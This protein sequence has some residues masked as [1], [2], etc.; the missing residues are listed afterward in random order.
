MRPEPASLDAIAS[1]LA[2]RAPLLSEPGTYDQEAAVAVCLRPGE[3]S[4]EALFVRRAEHPD[5]PWS[6][7]AA[8]PGGRR[9]PGDASLWE[10]AI[11]ETLEETGLDLRAAGTLLG[12]LDDVHPRVVVLPN[13]NIT[14]FVVSVPAEA[15]A[16]ARSEIVAVAWIPLADLAMPERAGLRI[17]ERPSGRR[18]F[19][20]IHIADLE[21]WGLTHR[22]L[23]QLLEIAGPP[24]I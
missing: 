18:E 5:D 4:I 24:S 6:G 23:T 9:D 21:I 13:L 3:R 20:T 11:R 15:K 17:V 14:P 1:R 7:D 19:P 22:I 2:R 16:A 10:T 8:F 12:P